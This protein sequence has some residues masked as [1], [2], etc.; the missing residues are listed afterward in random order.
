MNGAAIMGSRSKYA[1]IFAVRFIELVS[2]RAYPTWVLDASCARMFQN[3]GTAHANDIL[4]PAMA[5]ATAE[6]D[7]ATG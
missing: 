6:G 3:A 2:V 5:R 4:V 1:A 7:C